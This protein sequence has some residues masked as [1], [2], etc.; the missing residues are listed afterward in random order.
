MQFSV[1][2]DSSSKITNL[3]NHSVIIED[4]QFKIQKTLAA[5]Y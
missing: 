5:H 1:I 3:D 4:N 2:I